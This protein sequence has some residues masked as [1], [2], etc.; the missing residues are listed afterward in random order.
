MDRTESDSPR[1]ELSNGGLESVVTL[2]V[3]WQINY[4]CASPGKAIQLYFSVNLLPGSPSILTVSHAMQS[5]KVDQEIS[6]RV[7]WQ[8]HSNHNIVG[9]MIL[10]YLYICDAVI[11]SHFTWS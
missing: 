8:A 1:R 2:L 10:L 5:Q 4:S 6:P 9:F 7:N 3:R 11:G